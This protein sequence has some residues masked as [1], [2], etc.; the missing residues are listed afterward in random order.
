[1]QFVCIS[2][3]IAT[4]GDAGPY[5][6]RLQDSFEPRKYSTVCT[7]GMV[8]HSPDGRLAF[9]HRTSGAK[10]AEH[11]YKSQAEVEGCR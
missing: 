4:V 3:G 1:M 11:C 10:L 7:Q 2:H 5:C 9:H 8:H 6:G